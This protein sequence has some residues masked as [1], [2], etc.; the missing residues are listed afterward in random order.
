MCPTRPTRRSRRPG[1][2]TRHRGCRRCCDKPRPSQMVLQPP[3]Q[4]CPSRSCPRRKLRP[5]RPRAGC[6]HRAGCFRPARRKRAR[7]STGAVAGARRRRRRRRR[8]ALIWIEWSWWCMANSPC[9]RWRCY[10]MRPSAR[11]CSSKAVL[12]S[13]ERAAPNVL[14]RT[15]HLIHAPPSSIGAPHSSFARARCR[16]IRHQA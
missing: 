5:A 11:F 2:R 7:L 9:C 3:H 6:R 14:P 10:S 16:P 15:T 13:P 4:R 1:A 12:P 8:R